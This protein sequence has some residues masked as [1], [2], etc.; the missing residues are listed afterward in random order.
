MPFLRNLI[1]I[2]SEKAYAG[3]GKWYKGAGLAGEASRRNMKI[4]V[5]DDDEFYRGL[6]VSALEKAG[7]KIVIA[8][9]GE[10]AMKKA[11]SEKFDVVITDI[12]MPKKEGV[13]VVQEIKKASPEVKILTVSA[14]G[15]LQVTESLG[16][17][18]SLQ[19]PF[20][21]QQL[22]DKVN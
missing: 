9:D 14:G 1:I 16:A 5:I 15:G 21:A 6:M 8:E 4:L 13:V 20:S 3:T 10:M 19:K 17:D 18:T 2:I 7:H 11:H 12:Y 22:L